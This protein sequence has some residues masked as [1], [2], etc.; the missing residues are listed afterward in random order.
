MPSVAVPSVKAG[1]TFS[2]PDTALSRVTV[3]VMESPSLAEASAMVTAA[4][5]SS[6]VIVPVAVLVAVTV[7][8]VPETPRPTVNVSFVST[9]ASSV[10][11]TVKLCVSPAVPANVS[12]V[13]FSV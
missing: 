2:P 13:V 12:A 4:L 3:K 10:V 11:D 9:T 6:L 7:T 8:V 5:P 1:V